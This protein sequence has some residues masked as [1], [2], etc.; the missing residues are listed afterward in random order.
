VPVSPMPTLGQFFLVPGPQV[1]KL[2][3]KFVEVVNSLTQ[4]G[5]ESKK[6]FKHPEE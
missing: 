6:L 4:W 3:A 5:M 2:E 1:Q